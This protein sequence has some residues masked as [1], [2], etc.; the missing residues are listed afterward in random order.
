MKSIEVLKVEAGVKT[1]Y[2][3]L[4]PQGIIEMSGRSVPEN[5][6]DFYQ[7]VYQW[8]DHYAENPARET[9]VEIYFEYF[10]TSSSKCLLD[11]FRKLES[12]HRSGKCRVSVRWTF[13]KDDEDMMET[14]E[15]YSSM[16][17]IP[18]EIT[19]LED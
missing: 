8:L 10:N 9:K 4:D 5:T 6:A 19:A 12:I 18:F 2:V 1:P 16:V 3:L 7:P 11:I 15:D 17:G 14:G 13:D